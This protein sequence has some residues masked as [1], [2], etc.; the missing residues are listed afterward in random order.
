MNTRIRFFGAAAFEIVT[1]AG[2]RIMIDPFLDD[3][4]V[5]PVK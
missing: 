5:S 4:P 3:N 2:L 1:P